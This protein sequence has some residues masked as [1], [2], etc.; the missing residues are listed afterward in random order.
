[1]VKLG[2]IQTVSYSSN[3]SALK[4]VSQSLKILGRKEIDIVTLPEQWLKNNRISDFEQEFDSFKKIA[5]DFSMTIIPGAFYQ[6]KKTRLIISAP[7]IGPKGEI[8]GTQ[9][10]IH[11]FDYEQKLVMAG[12]RT[13][14]FQTN[15]KFGIIICYDMVFSDVANSL[16]KKGADVLFS[17]S[18]IVRRG[19]KPWQLYLQVRALENRVPILAANVQN[20]RFGGKSVIIDLSEDNGVIIPKIVTEL[21]GEKFTVRNFNLKKYKKSR[22][23]R[24]SDSRKF[25]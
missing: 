17:P 8:I 25:S 14:V 12:R 9:E 5:K 22:K 23:I 21:K 20:Y 16:V 19:V 11:P 18:R 3:E 7:V 4:K 24:F 15:C 6:R 2:L 1:M 13:K 10:K